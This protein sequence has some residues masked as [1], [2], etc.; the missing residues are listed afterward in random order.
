MSTYKQYTIKNTVYFISIY[1]IIADNC[2][3][4]VQLGLSGRM[5]SRTYLNKEDETVFAVELRVEEV[6]LILK[7]KSEETAKM[8]TNDK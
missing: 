3:K 5:Q 7:K 4:G 8:A 2:E 6:S 1:P